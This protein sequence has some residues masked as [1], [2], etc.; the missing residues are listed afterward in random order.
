MSALEHFHF[1]RP[2]WLLALPLVA[3]IWWLVRR[4][5]LTGGSL[6]TLIAPHLLDALTVNRDGKHWFK[7]ID[8]W[9]MALIATSLAAARP[10]WSKQASPWFSET[11][12]LV[13]ALEVSDSMRNNDLQP[14]R[15]ARA[16]FKILD[17]IGQT[18]GR[19]EEAAPH[20]LASPQLKAF[21]IAAINFKRLEKTLQ[22]ARRV[23][24]SKAGGRQSSANPR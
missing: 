19:Y 7:P 9:A 3:W 11:A 16:R 18:N 5:S 24:L 10:T 15:L 2:L 1:L 17:L 20:L 8:G 6:N 21:S 14:T 4:R 13:I 22:I 23:H 12:P